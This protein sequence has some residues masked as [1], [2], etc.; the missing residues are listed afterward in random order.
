PEGT[1]SKDGKLLPFQKGGFF[2]AMLA[3]VPIV[4]MVMMG[5]AKIYAKTSWVVNP[6][7]MKVRILPPVYP[8]DLPRGKAGREELMRIVRESMEEVIEKEGDF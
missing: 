4:P 7:T 5:G 6:G 1:R 8:G 2:I 3:G